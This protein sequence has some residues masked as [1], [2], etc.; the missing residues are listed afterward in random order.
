[1]ENYREFYCTTSQYTDD[2]LLYPIVEYKLSYLRYYNNLY[3]DAKKKILIKMHLFKNIEANY[4]T[5]SDEEFEYILKIIV[6]L[7][8]ILPKNKKGNILDKANLFLKQKDI[9]IDL[10]IGVLLCNGVVFF[11]DS[12]GDTM[13]YLKLITRL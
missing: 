1:M 6:E 7:Y 9:K 13:N 12:D 11:N 10:F 3:Q 5:F 8:N 4:D 2:C